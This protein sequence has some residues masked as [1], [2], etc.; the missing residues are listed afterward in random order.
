MIAGL[1]KAVTLYLSPVLC[2]TA[3]LLSLFAFLA[4]AAMLH[5]QVALLTVTPSL[6]LV[7]AG[8]QKDIDGPSVFLGAL[9]SCGRS[10]N[11]APINCTVP[12][13][14]PVY[15][16]SV[17]ANNAPKLLL[18]APAKG[19]P[20]FLAI[21]LTLSGIFFFTFTLI[22]FRHKLGKLQATL[23]KPLVQR[24]SAWMGF[25]GF[26]IGITAS[27]VIRMW[28]GKAVEDFN[29]SIISQGQQGAK[30]VASTGNAFTMVWVAY[31]FYAVPLIISL[32]KLNVTATKQ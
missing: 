28:F 12:T 26:L 21:A 10:S 9:G 2:L 7:Q 29:N 24:V 3:V 17:L 4:P 15:D 14:S 8:P 18:S 22:T 6:Q 32:S 27:L 5:D 19:T 1:S 31:A 25:F 20:V 13:V 16:L 11:A 23:D 30:L